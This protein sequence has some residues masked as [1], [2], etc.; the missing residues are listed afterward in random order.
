[1]TRAA[2]K[3]PPA[4]AGRARP[5]IRGR[6]V[7]AL[8][9]AAAEVGVPPAVLTGRIGLS[10]EALAADDVFVDLEAYLGLW[11]H[12]MRTVK[13]PGFPLVY[14]RTIK[15]ESFG[16]PGFAALTSP[17]GLTAAQRMARY[18]RLTSWC[19]SAGTV[20][21]PSASGCEW[22]TRPSWRRPWPWCV[23]SPGRR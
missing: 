23:R 3:P 21:G 12:V 18:Q 20:P 16:L 9:A 1:M 7:L 2:K 13:D 5:V 4:A 22:R 15:L 17:D 8:A 10:V 11:E 6:F 14:S 19:G